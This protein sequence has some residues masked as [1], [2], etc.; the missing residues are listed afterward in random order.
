MVAALDPTKQPSS[1]QD[2]CSQ[3]IKMQEA[4]QKTLEKIA[5]YPLIAVRMSRV[6]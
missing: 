5:L 4:D 1:A 6:G 3:W 2:C